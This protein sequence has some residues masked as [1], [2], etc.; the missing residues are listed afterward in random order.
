MI[1]ERRF[2]LQIVALLLIVSWNLAACSKTAS[3]DLGDGDGASEIDAGDAGWDAGD[4]SEPHQQDDTFDGQADHNDAGADQDLDAGADQD[5]DAGADQDLDAGADQDLD[6]GAD[7]DLDAGADQGPD[8]G[9]DGSGD[10]GPFSLVLPLDNEALTRQIVSSY[11]GSISGGQFDSSGWTTTSREDIIV[12]PLPQTLDTRRG[13][14]SISVSNFEWDL[15]TDFWEAWVLVSLDGHGVPFQSTPTGQAGIQTLYQGYNPDNPSLG[16][17]PV[18]YFNLADPAC[19]DWHN[20]TGETKTTSYWLTS[21]GATYT[22]TQEWD[23]AVDQV[24]FEGNGIVNRVI[25]LSVTSPDGSISANQ[26]YLMLNPCGSSKINTCGPWGGPN[27]LKGGPLGVT[28]S[29]LEL[30]I[31]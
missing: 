10:Q 4:D 22:I 18:A 29:H 12:V 23:G 9:P 13:S 16:H 27:G 8:A 21:D 31:F 1:L 14:L 26:M 3:T 20:C 7:E 2:R 17:R 15:T 30:E 28:Y 24:R 5:L 19:D 11:G 6:A 25:D